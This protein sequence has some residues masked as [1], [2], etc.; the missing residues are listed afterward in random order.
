MPNIEILAYCPSIPMD[1]FKTFCVSGA[2]TSAASPVIMPGVFKW[3]YSRRVLAAHF[4]TSGPND[5][6]QVFGVTVTQNPDVENE[7]VPWLK[8]IAGF[9]ER[10]MGEIGAFS[11]APPWT[12]SV[13]A[14]AAL[15]QLFE[16]GREHSE[17]IFKALESPGESGLA[18]TAEE[19]KA[20]LNGG[21]NTDLAGLLAEVKDVLKFSAFENLEL[22]ETTR[23]KG[24]G[25]T[26]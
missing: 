24:T 16:Q 17:N 21:E 4:F 2:P 25:S 9:D 7:P 5:P 22:A 15:D 12:T 13:T 8:K 3:L 14:N 1:E 23:S 26:T 6:L 11:P 19:F 20:A 18:F 10:V